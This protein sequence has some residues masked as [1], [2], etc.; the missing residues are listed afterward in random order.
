M[1]GDTLVVPFGGTLPNSVS[2]TLVALEASQVS[3]EDWPLVSPNGNA[4]NI[5][6]GRGNG[7]P[8]PADCCVEYSNAPMS[9]APVAGR[10]LPAKSAF[11]PG[12]F[13]PDKFTPAPMHGELVCR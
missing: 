13:S 5:A 7:T 2:V 12:R 3:V 1:P 11:K 6:C 4:L 10:G 8:P 9:Q